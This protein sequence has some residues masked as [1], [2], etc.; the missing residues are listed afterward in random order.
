MNDVR[1][2]VQKRSIEKKKKILD[3]GFALFCEKGYY[4]TNTIEIAKRAGISTGALY[5]YFKDKKQIY[6]AAFHD[7]L[8]NISGHLLE[9]LSLQHPFSIVSFVEN[10]I[11]YYIDLYADTSHAL[12]QLRMMI[13]EDTDINRHFSNFEN[14]YFLKI[15]ELLNKNGIVQDDLFEKVYTCCILIDALRQEKSAF[16]HNS[17]DFNIFKNQVTKTVIALLSN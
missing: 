7:Y 17:L 16:S 1:E 3:A 9:K 12:A 15:T 4:K 13:S 6:I 11:C 8:E 5:S 2:P 10:W 14:E